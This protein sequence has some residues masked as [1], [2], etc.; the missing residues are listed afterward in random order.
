SFTGAVAI[1][2]D[3]NPVGGTLT[4]N[5]PVNAVNGVATFANLT[6]DKVGTGYTLTATSGTLTPATSN[7]FNITAAPPPPAT[8][9]VTTP[10]SGPSAPGSYTVTVDGRQ[11][12]T[13]LATG[14]VTYSGLNA[15]SYSV[16]LNGVSSNCSVSEANPQTITVPASGTAQ[17]RFTI[18]CVAPNQPPTAAFTSSCS[19]LTC[20]F[21]DQS[22]DPDGSVTIW[23]W[24]FGD[25]GTATTRN[26]S[27]AYGTGGDYTVTLTVTDNAGATS[28]P[29]S[30]TV[31]PRAPNQ[32]PTAAFTSSCSGLTCSFTDQ[33]TDPDGSVMGWSWD[34]GDGATATTRNPSHPYATGGDY[35]VTLTVTDNQGAQS[36]PVSHTVSPR[37]PNQPP[38]AG[39]TSSCSGL[40]CS[41]TDQSTDPDGS[42][43][44]WQWD[45]G[46]GATATTRN[47]S[48][49]YGTGG[50]YTVTLTVTDNQ[51]ASS[52]P[53]THTVSPRAP[54]QPPTAAF[55][56][57]CSGLTCSFTDQSTDPDGSVSNW[58]WNFGD[59]TTSTARN[60][61]HPYSAGGT[62]NVTLTVT[63]NQGATDQVTN[64]VSPSAPNQPPT[65]ASTPSC[66]GLTCSFTDRSTDPDGSVIGWQWNFGD[67]ATSNS[68]N[69]SHPYGA[70]GDY[71]VTLTVT[72]DPG[73]SSA[74]VTHTV[75]P[76][77]PNQPPTAAFTSSCSGL[78]CS[79]TDQST[80]P[81]GSVIGWSWNFGDGATSN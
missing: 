14:S 2:I 22:T 57:S 20:S 49:P 66:T 13:I 75:S 3:N 24:D 81:D 73:A 67:G 30:H 45:F 37:A 8:P 68:R 77:A 31:S 54:N 58:N 27:H 36:N 47:P 32:P 61:S 48:H 10:T 26:P 38:T 1:A 70:G 52:A 80:D 55:T 34:F 50:D 76:R 44:I 16:Q 69:P 9:S 63:D 42:V 4:G 41:F 59:G 65:A 78:T 71:T 35:T 6:I 46:D 23:Q 53:V 51:N 79:F 43:T 60:P 74:P 21:T 64:P 25:G 29:V 19:G 15:G 17:A 11:S 33:S 18:S 5:A 62:Y 56:A 72:D 12:K 40:T 7:S 28:A 39:F